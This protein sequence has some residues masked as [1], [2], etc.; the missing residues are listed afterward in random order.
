MKLKTNCLAEMRNELEEMFGV[1]QS[2]RCRFH[3]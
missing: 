2:A 3:M 1:T